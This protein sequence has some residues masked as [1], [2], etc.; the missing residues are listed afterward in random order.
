MLKR[1]RFGACPLR[2]ILM[3]RRRSSCVM[4]LSRPRMWV[5]P[6]APIGSRGPCCAL[7]TVLIGKTGSFRSSLISPWLTCAP[8]C[9]RCPK[10]PLRRSNRRKIQAPLTQRPQR[11]KGE[12]AGRA[13]NQPILC[14]HL[15]SS[16]SA[17]SRP[18]ASA[19]ATS[20]HNSGPDLRLPLAM[21]DNSDTSNP[22]SRAIW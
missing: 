11:R 13:K 4:I 19:S 10:T 12:T 7:A 15:G 9:C 18:C 20:V 14:C 6:W 17:R 8:C 5:M 1:H 2:R 3:E 22:V 16:V 21:F